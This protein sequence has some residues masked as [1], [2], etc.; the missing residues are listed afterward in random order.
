MITYMEYIRSY[1]FF[2]FNLKLYLCILYNL[3]YIFK[4]KNLT[5]IIVIRA[6]CVIVREIRIKKKMLKKK[7][8]K[9]YLNLIR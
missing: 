1:F 7:N 4:L 8:I 3:I 9:K 2:F 5:C 6:Q